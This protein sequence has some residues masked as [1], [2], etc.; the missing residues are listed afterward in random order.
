MIEVIVK[1]GNQDHSV[2]RFST[3]RIL[4]G[5]AYR[6][7]PCSAIQKLAA[8]NYGASSALPVSLLQSWYR[9]NPAI[10]RVALN[11]KNSVVGY[12][13]SLPLFANAFSRT[14]DIDF[15]E[16]SIAADDIDES[17]FPSS[18]GIFISSIVVAPE[19]QNRAPNSL[20]LRL[21]L[22][23]D[24]IGACPEGNPIIRI[25]AQALSPKGEACMRSLGM[26]VCGTT[27][28]GWKVYYG[29]LS[30][31]DLHGIHRELQRK[32]ETRFKPA[33]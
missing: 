12:I 22:M 6:A 33:D 28:A 18:G 23:E 27:T 5:Q 17:F 14:I 11:S 20:L 3:L 31:P 9:Q 32:I 16:C 7:D 21:T 19:Y 8:K 29:K 25:S 1:T 4:R 26:K 15:Q 10:F 13:S 2:C 24:L 30:K